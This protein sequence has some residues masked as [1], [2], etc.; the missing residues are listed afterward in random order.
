MTMGREGLI[1][2]GM[3]GATPLLTTAFQQSGMQADI[4][5][6]TASSATALISC[7]ISHPMDTI[8]TCMQGD[9]KGENYKTI[10]HTARK[11]IA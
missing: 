6:A 8:K 10:T 11:L 2:T 5:M 1:C 3:L 4:A 7:T 9:V